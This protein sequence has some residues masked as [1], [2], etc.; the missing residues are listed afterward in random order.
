MPTAYLGI[1]RIVPVPYLTLVEIEQLVVVLRHRRSLFGIKG[2]VR[3]VGVNLASSILLRYS[4]LL[5]FDIEASVR[6]DVEA[7]PRKDM[8][9]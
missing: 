9:L 6:N 2:P 1:E 8:A 3:A 4:Y 5:V 7:S